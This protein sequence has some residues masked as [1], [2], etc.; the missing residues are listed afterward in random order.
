[1]E[2]DAIAEAFSSHRFADAYPYL[3]D[4]VRW[5]LVGGPILQGAGEVRAACEATL[6]ELED[7]RT[8]FRRFRTIVGRDTVV[9]DAIG[10]YHD[11]T[12]MDS[13]V[14]SCDI[15]DFA[16]GRISAMTSY[17]VELPSSDSEAET[18]NGPAAAS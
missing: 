12:G 1:M 10:V 5:H 6:S 15:F 13:T 18:A 3:A 17:T 16:D 4:D 9:V 8:E 11:P 2:I 7:T 14:A